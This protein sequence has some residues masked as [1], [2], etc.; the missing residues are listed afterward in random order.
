MQNNTI[1]PKKNLKNTRQPNKTIQYKTT[2][3][4]KTIQDKTRQQHKQRK[5]KQNTQKN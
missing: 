5:T 1:H 3:Q 2:K 4:V